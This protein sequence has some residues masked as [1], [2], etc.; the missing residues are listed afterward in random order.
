MRVSSPRRAATRGC[1]RRSTGGREPS[2]IGQRQGRGLARAPVS[3]RDRYA[4]VVPAPEH[5]SSSAGIVLANPGAAGR[6]W[7]P[8]NRMRVG[9]S[10]PVAKLHLPLDPGVGGGD[11]KRGNR[12]HRDSICAS[13]GGV[14][15]IG[16]CRARGRAVREGI[17]STSTV[18]GGQRPR[19]RVGVERQAA[20]CRAAPAPRTGSRCG[21]TARADVLQ[22][23]AAVF[24]AIGASQ[25]SPSAAGR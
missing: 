20:M 2:V 22:N 19:I 21:R 3:V 9:A 6:S 13:R 1:I 8:R 23:M 7:R 15:A 11:Y 17:P 4:G 10:P 16:Q 5:R 12:L 25:D 24:D 14:R 18:V